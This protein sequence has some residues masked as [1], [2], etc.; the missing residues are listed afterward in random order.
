MALQDSGRLLPRL[1]ELIPASLSAGEQQ[2]QLTMH[3]VRKHVKRNSQ[4]GGKWFPCQLLLWVRWAA[5][6]V[7]SKEHPLD[8]KQNPSHHWYHNPRGI[9]KEGIVCLTNIPQSLQL[10]LAE[11]WNRQY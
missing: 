3:S 10:R 9:H 7:E 11:V 4:H 1:S 8:Q 5:Q 2:H 6:P